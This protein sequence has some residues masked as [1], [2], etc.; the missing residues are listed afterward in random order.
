MQKVTIWHNP[1]CSKSREA[2]GLL[3]SR[4]MEIQIIDYLNTP[5]DTQAI[6]RTLTL[7]RIP[8]RELMRTNEDKYYALHLDDPCVTPTQL[9]NAMHEYPILIQRP[10]VFANGSACIGRPPETVLEIL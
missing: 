10:I 5:P 7:L 8:P 4:H 2:L 3:Q 9:I 6:E 1:R